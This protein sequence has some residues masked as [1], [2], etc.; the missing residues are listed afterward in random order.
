MNLAT[1]AKQKH[2]VHLDNVIVS[3]IWLG[4]QNKDY[5][6][7]YCYTFFGIASWS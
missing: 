1:V 5:Y 3:W 4:L 2:M 7:V 6:T